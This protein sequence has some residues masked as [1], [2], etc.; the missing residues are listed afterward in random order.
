MCHPVYVY[1]IA[2]SLYITA[3]HSYVKMRLVRFY[4]A[5]RL[6]YCICNLGSQNTTIIQP[7]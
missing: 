2:R 3:I 4:T 7:V 6:A 5:L 1:V